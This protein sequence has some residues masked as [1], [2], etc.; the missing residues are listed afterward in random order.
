MPPKTDAEKKNLPVVNDD[1]SL[2]YANFN[3][4]S[5][6]T[7]VDYIVFLLQDL[8]KKIN[9][10]QYIK[11][12][13]EHHFKLF[14]T[15]LQDRFSLKNP[16]GLIDDAVNCLTAMA[17]YI[18]INYFEQ[19]CNKVYEFILLDNLKGETGL[20]TCRNIFAHCNEYEKDRLKTMFKVFGSSKIDQ[21]LSMPFETNNKYKFLHFINSFAVVVETKPELFT[22]EEIEQIVDKATAR[23]SRHTDVIQI[24]E[25]FLGIIKNLSKFIQPNTLNYIF[26]DFAKREENI[27]NFSTY[28]VLSSLIETA[29]TKL[30]NYV[31]DVMELL[32]DYI[33][34]NF[35]G[36]MAEDPDATLIANS[37]KILKSIAILVN[38]FPAT[39]KQFE[40]KLYEFAINFS[41]ILFETISVEEADESD[42]EDIDDDEI[43]GDANLE[44]TALDAGSNEM[45]SN[46]GSKIRAISFELLQAL[47]NQDKSNYISYIA[48]SPDILENAIIDIDPVVE[49]EAF[50]LL[51]QTE[52]IINSGIQV[53][54]ELSDELPQIHENMLNAVRFATSNVHFANIVEISAKIV[55]YL[56]DFD[57]DFALKFLDGALQHFGDESSRQVCTLIVAISQRCLTENIVNAIS[58]FVENADEFKNYSILPIISMFESVLI[59]KP[60][61]NEEL[62]SIAEFL[63]SKEESKELFVNS[64]NALAI[65]AVLYSEEEITKTIV[66][67]FVKSLGNMFAMLRLSGAFTLIASTKPEL[68]QPHAKQ[69]SEFI[70]NCL[71]Q[72]SDTGVHMRGLYAFEYCGKING[73]ETSKVTTQAIESITSNDAQIRSLALKNVLKYK[74]ESMNNAIHNSIKEALTKPNNKNFLESAS[75]F[76]FGCQSQNYF[77]ELIKLAP[78]DLPVVIG[79]ALSEQSAEQFIGKDDS[80]SIRILGYYALKADISNNSKLVDHLFGLTAQNSENSI[81]ASYS[82]GLAAVKSASILNKLISQSKDANTRQSALTALAAFAEHVS[83]SKVDDK[84]LEEIF[85]FFKGFND[86]DKN[87]R[88]CSQSISYIIEVSDA[89]LEKIFE[90]PSQITFHALALYFPRIKCEK[91]ASQV[92]EKALKHINPEKPLLTAHILSVLVENAKLEGGE[93]VIIDNFAKIESCAKFNNSHIEEQTVGDMLLKIDVGQH[94]RATAVSLLTIVVDKAADYEFAKRFTDITCMALADP[95]PDVSIKAITL[96]KRLAFVNG[97]AL[98][99]AEDD[100]PF[101]ALLSLEKNLMSQA[102]QK[103]VLDQSIKLEKAQIEN[104]VIDATAALAIA[105]VNSQE[106]KEFKTRF[107]DSDEFQ[108]ALNEE[109]SLKLQSAA[110]ESSAL[111]KFMTEFAPE[112]ALIFKD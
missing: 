52:M 61:Y 12:N 81:A 34:K 83:E 14:F 16:A 6:S 57:E 19:F 3:Q 100:K 49:L 7:D 91:K 54:K 70:I 45:S 18:D 107:D 79:K 5:T 64:I 20:I 111:Y 27:K 23:I 95:K 103:D 93:K 109:K 82:I 26:N 88:T 48:G 63:I 80:L 30:S 90:F 24:V 56:Q 35:D 60:T 40:E 84:L 108:Q 69:L 55:P 104:Y 37:T 50:K 15:R 42:E 36:L 59:M 4:R 47:L 21:I 112:I 13:A 25:G 92:V 73:F 105:H 44:V 41:S 17:R 33:S 58:I 102:D 72:K 99:E 51:L 2:N 39:T 67:L 31:K 43:F 71:K 66:E 9:E 76:Y 1:K 96:L 62:A 98:Q 74:E 75:E 97:I 53:P 65:F 11:F 89:I 22:E 29:P 85:G 32:I 101:K 8:T 10:N 78:A 86:N 106:F 77:D 110:K 68:L 87:A 94:M 28:L 46:K 38:T